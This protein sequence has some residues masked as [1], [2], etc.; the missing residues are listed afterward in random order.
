M[1]ILVFVCL[2]LLL[3]ACF[4]ARRYAFRDIFTLLMR[5][6]I[7]TLVSPP[8]D[9]LLMVLGAGNHFASHMR[10]TDSTA[11]VTSMAD[12]LKQNTST[13]SLSLFF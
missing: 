2:L 6:Q 9:D 8:I 4:G 5:L 11:P 7:Q 10:S 3:A 13:C 12:R 1:S